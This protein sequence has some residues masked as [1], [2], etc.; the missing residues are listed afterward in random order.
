MKNV[1]SKFT[2]LRVHPNFF[3]GK[4]LTVPKFPFARKIQSRLTKQVE[5][6]EDQTPKEDTEDKEIESIQKPNSMKEDSKPPLE[7]DHSNVKGY[8]EYLYKFSRLNTVK[9][10]KSNE[11]EWKQYYDFILSKIKHFTKDDLRFFVKTI[12][13]LNIVDEHTDELLNKLLKDNSVENA[14]LVMYTMGKLHLQKGREEI[15][16]KAIKIICSSKIE[17]Q[18]IQSVIPFIWGCAEL[19]LDN[20]DLNGKIDE[21]VFKQIEDFDEYVKAS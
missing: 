15:L 1:L 14:F 12:N 21:F 16:D 10:I 18:T 9:S 2:K 17:D 5:Q 4:F 20:K 7:F 6:R 19:K 3:E 13:F 11:A 8:I